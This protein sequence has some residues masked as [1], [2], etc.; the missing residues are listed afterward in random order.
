[1]SCEGHSLYL[2]HVLRP[3]ATNVPVR[4]KLSNLV[5]FPYSKQ[6]RLQKIGKVRRDYM[7]I[8]SLGAAPIL[9]YEK[10]TMKKTSKPHRLYLDPIYPTHLSFGPRPGEGWFVCAA[11]NDRQN[12]R[13]PIPRRIGRAFKAGIR[14]SRGSRSPPS[15]EALGMRAFPL[16]SM[17]RLAWMARK[18]RSNQD[19]HLNSPCLGGASA[20]TGC[21]SHVASAVMLDQSS[22]VSFR[23]KQLSGSLARALE[24]V[25][26]S[27]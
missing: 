15:F 19:T 10:K 17:V 9:P 13:R 18:L 12:Y 8:H 20:P 3:I 14:S 7:K 25:S 2:F 24:M 23:P 1:M 6:A 26:F 21:R 27:R 22:R 4:G 5:V 11:S 16:V